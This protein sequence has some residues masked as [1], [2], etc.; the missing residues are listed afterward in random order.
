MSTLCSVQGGKSNKFTFLTTTYTLPY[1]WSYENTIED[2]RKVSLM[3][4]FPFL[5]MESPAKKNRRDGC[6][7]LVWRKLVKSASVVQVYTNQ[8]QTKWNQV[9]WI[10][11]ITVLQ[12]NGLLGRRNMT[13]N[14]GIPPSKIILLN[15]ARIPCRNGSRK[16]T[17]SPRVLM[18]LPDCKAPNQIEHTLDIME[19]LREEKLQPDHSRL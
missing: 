11:L 16:L 7:G 4:K 5:M 12:C 10:P 1:L 17:K 18:W 6:W 13:P 2:E 14:A 9:K 19:P 8:L 15:T 3:Q